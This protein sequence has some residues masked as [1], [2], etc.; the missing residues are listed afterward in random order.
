MENDV[1][2][3]QWLHLIGLIAVTVV[4]LFLSYLLA[5]PFLSALTSAVAL[6]VLLTPLQRR[7]ERRVRPAGLASALTVTLLAG[8]LIGL[9]ALIGERILSEA[10][11]A[12]LLI[13]ENISSGSWRRLLVDHSHLG[14]VAGWIEHQVNLPRTSE[15]TVSW[16]TK[17]REFA[18]SRIGNPTRRRSGNLLFPL[19]F[20]A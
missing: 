15:N 3:Q 2:T 6:A 18:C 8:L 17:C 1:R 7:V 20:F 11:T 19:L 4:G 10:S 9:S 16:L 14:P 13:S 5:A 12:A